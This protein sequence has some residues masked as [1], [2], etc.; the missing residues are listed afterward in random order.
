MF[1]RSL[2]GSNLPRETLPSSRASVAVVVAVVALVALVATPEQHVARG[3]DM[4]VIE[5]EGKNEFE[6]LNG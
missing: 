6:G 4:S 3:E 2:D 5:S 1:I